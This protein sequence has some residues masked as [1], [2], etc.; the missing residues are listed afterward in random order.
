MKGINLYPNR[1]RKYY[2]ATPTT[3]GPQCFI[4]PISHDAQLSNRVKTLLAEQKDFSDVILNEAVVKCAQ[5]DSESILGNAV[6]GWVG[7]GDVGKDDRR[8]DNG[9]GGV[10]DGVHGDSGNTN[11]ASA[12]A[13]AEADDKRRALAKLLR[14]DIQWPGLEDMYE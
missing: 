6:F 12:S 10:E 7:L 9:R 11:E 14:L 8:K 4:Y 13:S 1:V 5:E 2:V 3:I